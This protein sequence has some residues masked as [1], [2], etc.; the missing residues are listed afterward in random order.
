MLY[1][2]LGFV[3]VTLVFWS[4][5]KP[6]KSVVAIFLIGMIVILIARSFFPL[7]PDNQPLMFGDKLSLGFQLAGLGAIVGA[8]GAAITMRVIGRHRKD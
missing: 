2:L 1:K 6:R 4:V 5:W 3:A 7:P 8:V